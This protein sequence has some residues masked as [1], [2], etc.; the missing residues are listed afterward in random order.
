MS[1]D[2]RSE[3]RAIAD[4]AGARL[5]ALRT[6]GRR[7]RAVGEALPLLLVFPGAYAL[8]ELLRWALGQPAAPLPWWLLLLGT[9][10]VPC[11][12]VA[13]V[14]LAAFRR[15][16]DPRDGL[17]AVDRA[18]DL[19][20]RLQAA[21]AFLGE[22]TPTPFMRAAMDDAAQHVARARAAAEALTAL[23]APAAP[24]VGRRL[25]WAVPAVLLALL[26]LWLGTH[27]RLALATGGPGEPVPGHVVADGQLPPRTDVPA[28]A[29]RQP[30]PAPQRRSPAGE[31]TSRPLAELKEPPKETR[32]ATG[33]GQAAEAS[34]AQGSS[35]AKATPSNQGQAAK[36]E[37]K[38]EQ[39]PPKPDT[40]ETPPPD[41]QPP[42]QKQAN[43]EAGTTAG[44][45]ASKGSN[46]NP[47]TTDWATRDA[48]QQPDDTQLENDDDIQDEDEEQES[49]GGIQPNLRDRK[50]PVNRDLR[51]GFGNRKNPDANGRGGPS[52]Q[53][54]S[55]G[56]ASLVLGVPIPDRIKGQPNPGKTKITQERIE[57]KAEDAEPVDA[58]TRAPRSSPIGPL[59]PREVP[60]WLRQMVKKYFLHDRGPAAP[61]TP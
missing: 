41:Q 34:S 15:P 58:E 30:Q 20:D 49:R 32:G 9:V 13:G 11:L 60:P 28:E 8:Y 42:K 57:P 22:T 52:E 16:V 43:E 31:S 50:P 10:L 38:K 24:P 2:L 14:A 48:T 40:K 35:N 37:A 1:G 19:Q 25:G 5:R 55:R 59:P 4:G 3:L 18:L 6:T 61:E 51:I 47:A 54:K 36:T 7:R 29:P 46:R 27:E 53:K 21:D 17:G 39:A 23:Q 12:W 45:G 44:R 26:G 56:V 33:Q